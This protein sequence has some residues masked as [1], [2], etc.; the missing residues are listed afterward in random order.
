[1][2]TKYA[3][4]RVARQWNLYDYILTGGREHQLL[5]VSPPPPKLLGLSASIAQPAASMGVA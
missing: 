3:F 2:G 1:M 4:K 5:F